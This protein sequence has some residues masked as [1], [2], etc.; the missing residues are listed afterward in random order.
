[1]NVVI[2]VIVVVWDYFLCFLNIEQHCLVFVS[3]KI[4]LR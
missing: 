2:V 1:M 4:F 3:I